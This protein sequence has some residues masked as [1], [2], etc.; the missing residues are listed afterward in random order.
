MNDLKFW[1][2]EQPKQNIEMKHADSVLLSLFMRDNEQ[3]NI[4]HSHSTGLIK[5]IGVIDPEGPEKYNNTEK[6]LQEAQH[7]KIAYLSGLVW[8][9]LFMDGP[10]HGRQWKVQGTIQIQKN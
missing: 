8:F 2:L 7:N 1:P 5:C 3:Y 9:S 6:S 10:V 4:S